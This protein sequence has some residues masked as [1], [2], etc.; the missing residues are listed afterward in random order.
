[1]QKYPD[2]AMESGAARRETKVEGFKLIG[3]FYPHLKNLGVFFQNMKC[4]KS[5]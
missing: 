3:F 2:S 1:M 5:D 4:I